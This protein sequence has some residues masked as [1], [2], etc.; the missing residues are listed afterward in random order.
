VSLFAAGSGGVRCFDIETGK[1][2]WIWKMD[3]G[4]HASMALSA[5]GHRLLAATPNLGSRVD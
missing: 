4:M 3:K 5:D 1:S 2:E